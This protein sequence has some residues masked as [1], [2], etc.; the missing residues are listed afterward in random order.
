MKTSPDKAN[1]SMEMAAQD[2]KYQEL[3]NVVARIQK[4]ASQLDCEDGDMGGDYPENQKLV[5]DINNFVKLFQKSCNDLEERE[6]LV[7]QI[8]ATQEKALENGLFNSN[9][10]E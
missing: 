3:N 9:K 1:F 10:E 2:V 6:V 7:K 8:L 5:Q 4:A